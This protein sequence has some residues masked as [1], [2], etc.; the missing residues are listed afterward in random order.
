MEELRQIRAEQAALRK[1]LDEFVG[2]F[3]NAKFPYGRATDRWAR[4]TP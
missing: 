2:V 4:R 3:L 1:L